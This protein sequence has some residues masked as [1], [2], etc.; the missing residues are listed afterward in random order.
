MSVL[1]SQGNQNKAPRTVW[2]KQQ[3][4]TVSQAGGCKFRVSVL[5]G[6]VSS[7]ASLGLESGIFSLGLHSSVCV[8]VPISSQ[9]NQYIGLG[10]PNNPVL[11]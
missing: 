9:G 7:K 5:A 1:L 4:F 8:C 3:T 11:T 10:L 2:L 6:L